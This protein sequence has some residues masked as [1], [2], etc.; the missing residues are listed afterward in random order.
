MKT[1]NWTHTFFKAGHSTA[2][3]DPKTQARTWV[4]EN[5]LRRL[6]LHV[7][8]ARNAPFVLIQELIWA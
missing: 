1:G 3:G 6:P 4:C 5:E 7:A 8:V 2:H